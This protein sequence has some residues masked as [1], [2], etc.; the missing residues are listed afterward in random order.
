[1]KRIGLLF[2]LIL[3]G[4]ASNPPIEEFTLARS[5]IDAAKQ[6]ES[7]RYAPGLWYQAEEN[8]RRG[9]V[10]Y[11][12][13]DFDIAKDFFLKAKQFAEKAENKARKEKGRVK[14]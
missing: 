7:D 3:A 6:Y 10:A 2:C 9:Q 11:K 8:Y 12:K 1:M 4:C 13:E 14:E 5:A